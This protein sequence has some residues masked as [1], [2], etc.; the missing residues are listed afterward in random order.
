MNRRRYILLAA[1]FV[2]SVILFQGYYL[3]P[4]SETMREDIQAKYGT[5]QKYETFLKGSGITET[6]I[7]AAI[8]DMKTI[9]ERLIP[10]KS[11][12]LSS[13]AI[14]RVIA[15]LTQRS[16]LTVQTVRPIT[17]VKANNFVTIPV[18]FEGS[19]TIKQVSDFLKAVEENA[20]MLRIDKMSFSVTN[21]QN[22]K[23]L[24]LKIQLSGLVRT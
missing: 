18:Y 9:E 12:F 11:E 7:Q 24:K 23:E 21:M 19:G 5:L 15:E 2:I 14:Q 22:P 17:A 8:N 20:L 6:E 10:E 16:G 3:A 1:F 13:A 4:K